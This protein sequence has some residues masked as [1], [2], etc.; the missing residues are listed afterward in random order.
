[1]IFVGVGIGRKNVGIW[2]RSDRVGSKLLRTRALLSDACAWWSLLRKTYKHKSARS[3]PRWGGMRFRTEPLYGTSA[4]ICAST[5][6]RAA[7]RLF[8][9]YIVWVTFILCRHDANTRSFGK[10]TTRVYE[11]NMHVSLAEVLCDVFTR[12][13][14]HKVLDA[15][16]AHD[17]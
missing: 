1:M 13:S 9:T 16:C 11:Q 12:R 4:V 8:C 14:Y 15:S 6:T 10:R 7:G 2:F 3:Q 5:T 17:D